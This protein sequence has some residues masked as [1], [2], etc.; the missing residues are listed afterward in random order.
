MAE[1]SKKTKQIVELLRQT[2]SL[3]VVSNFLK[4]RSLT[5]SAG[6]WEDML[7]KRILPA[8]EANS[9]TDG[10]LIE[11]LRSVEECGRQHVFLYSCPKT[12][13][14]ELLDKNRV[15]AI[16]KARKEEG[17]L[18][19]PLVLAEPP[20][21]KLVDVRWETA[22]VDLSL[23]IKEIELRTH[24]RFV[25]VEHYP[26]GTFHKVYEEKKERAVNLAK[27]HRHGLLE[28]RIASH[29][30]SSKYE[31]DVNR[32]WRS[33]DDLIPAREFAELSLSK[34]KDLLWTKRGELTDKIRYSDSTLRDEHGNV[35]KAATGSEMADLAANPAVAKSLDHLLKNDPNAYCDE[36]NFWFKQAN[37]LSSDI[38]VMLG[39]EVHEFALPSNCSA[40]DYQHVLDQIRL[41]NQ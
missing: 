1:K 7:N 22:K 35:L 30:N 11:L 27:L 10:E 24:T 14:A 29:S 36:T 16:L 18:N 25:G 5:H 41:F 15:T 40:G 31:I 38:R 8:V 34:A 4:A 9:L 6:S 12:K 3:T 26:N 13:A 2:T 23:T 33:I 39:G 32:F 21:P 20:K 17:L 19:E 37:G 28:I